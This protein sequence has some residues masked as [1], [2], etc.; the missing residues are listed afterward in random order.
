MKVSKASGLVVAITS[1]L[2]LGA[3]CST[4]KDSYIIVHS[5]V[6]CD[7]PRVFQLRVTITNNGRSSQKTI[8]E[9]ASAELGFPSSISLVLPSG[10]SGAVDLLVEALDNKSTLV[11]QGTVSGT[12]AVGGRVDLQVQLVATNISSPV[13][14]AD[15]G[16]PSVAADGGLPGKDSGVGADFSAIT[17]G[18][19]FGQ[20]AVGM[21]STCALRS[22]ASLWCWG[23]NSYGQLLLS[24]TSSRLTPVQVGGVAW[25]EVVAGQTHSCAIRIDGTLTCWGNNAS[26]QLGAATTSLSMVQTEVAGNLWQSITTGSYQSCGIMTDGTL[27]CW[28]DNVNGQLG[29]GDTNGRPLPSQVTGQGWSQV[30]SN[31]LHTCAM[32]QDGTLWCWGLSADLQIGDSSLSVYDV[33]TQVAGTDWVQV[34][35]GY[36]HTCALKKDATL[37]CWGGNYSGQLGNATVP[38]SNTSKVSVPTQVTGS[39][40]KS[41][42]AGLSHTCAVALDGTLWCWG[43]NAHGQLGDKTQATKSTPVNI[44]VAG[45]SWV[46][47]AAGASHT[48][49]IAAGGSLWCWGD[50]T[51]GQLGIGSNELHSSPVRVVQ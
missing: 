6:N 15:S 4:A 50:N 28:G 51:V 12:I 5:D 1:A 33:P 9:K 16:T 26:G 23:S 31:Y 8:P 3:S 42:S 39:A 32:K 49:A 10:R 44:V 36:Y 29:V 46:A 30:S 37:W 17:V 43:D 34:T 21:Q 41:V 35:T 19:P 47:A 25:G 14:A 22:D 2:A 24:N 18:A 38:V 13:A 20:V 45:Q 48:C 27:W 7:V 11:G 40:W